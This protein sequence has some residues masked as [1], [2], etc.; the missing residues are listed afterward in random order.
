MK[1]LMWWC[2]PPLLA[3]LVF[4]GGCG[5]D[6]GESGGA[7]GTPGA[8]TGA[9]PAVGTFEEFDCEAD[10]P[11]T[12]PDAS[13][14]PVDVTD[15][16]GATVSLEAPPEAIVSLSAAHVEV[17]YAIGAG[18]QLI[19]G[20][21]FSDCPAAA[22]EELE[23]VD[24]FAPSVEAIAALEPDLVVLG[25]ADPD[26]QQ[27]LAGVG[28]GSFL[29]ESP[30]EVDGV[31]DDIA[32]L[33][34]MTGHEKEAQAL[35]AGMEERIEVIVDGLPEGE[36]PSVFHE[37]DNLLY[38]AGPGSFVADLYE[39]LKAENIAAAT[40]QAFPQLTQEAIID[41]APDVIVL[42]DEEAGESADT[43][44][45]RP[46]WDSIPAV[47]N[48]RI[49]AVDPDIVSRPGPRLIEALEVLAGLLYGE[50]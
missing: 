32:L 3:L 34:R 27:A 17:L 47:Q 19:A 6:E 42:A 22:A 4:A 41:A 1:G 35:T 21:L 46:G 29:M 10:Y 26:L 31:L 36:A 25:F 18:D 50:P 5:D 33:G 20:D 14:F 12:T 48:E 45:A 40:G 37:V 39:I 43:V 23:H 8:T 24:S 44:S 11:G 49:Y 38:S 2:L 7:T 9:S 13:A 16:S 15:D 28:V 30:A